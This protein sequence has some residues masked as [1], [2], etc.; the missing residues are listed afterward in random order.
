ML[1]RLFEPF[2]TSKPHGMGIGLSISRSIVDLHGGRLFGRNNSEGGA[3]FSF[4]LPVQPIRE[5]SGVVTHE[6]AITHG[7]RGG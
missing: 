6:R 3:T 2:H 1:D 4:V 5:P 7:V